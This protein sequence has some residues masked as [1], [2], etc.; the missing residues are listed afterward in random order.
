[1]SFPH[2]FLGLVCVSPWFRR[3][4]VVFYHVLSG[5]YRPTQVITMAGWY[6]IDTAVKSSRCASPPLQGP[7]MSTPSVDGSG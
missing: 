7:G 1:M 6:A 3:G 2:E 5:S 4:F